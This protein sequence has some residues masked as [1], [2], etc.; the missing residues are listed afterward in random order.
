MMLT[1]RWI[2]VLL[3]MALAGDMLAQKL[4][5]LTTLF[6]Q[7]KTAMVTLTDG[8]TIK[9]PNANIFLKNAS[10]IYFQGSQAKEARMDL[11]LGVSF[12]DRSFVNINNRLAYLVD[13]IKGNS[14]YCVETIDMEAYEDYLK[15]NVN[16]TYIDLSHDHLDTAT[17][18]LDIN[19]GVAFPVKRTFYYRLD[20]KFVQT[21]P[22][23]L[24]RELSKNRN[25][26]MRAVSNAHDFNWMDKEC[27]MNLLDKLSN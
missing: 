6:P 11:V 12:D 22:R 14:L 26:I 24:N 18:G 2:L 27:L 9:A 17:T 1:K 16:F 23:E 25:R 8:R 15:N 21:D 19:D 5:T 7:N 10:L 13:S 4:T 3:L 20:G